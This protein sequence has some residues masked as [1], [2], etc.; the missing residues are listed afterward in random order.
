MQK[1]QIKTNTE[2]WHKKIEININRDKNVN[3]TLKTGGWEVIQFW[4]EEIK[5]NLNLCIC[6]IEQAVE[7]RKN[8]KVL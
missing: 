8:I 3:E 6:K 4:R 2:F 7:K 5:K 1:K